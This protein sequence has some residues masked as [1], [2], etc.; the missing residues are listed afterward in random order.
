VQAGGSVTGLV[1]EVV[2][3]KLREKI[4]GETS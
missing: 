2:E 3:K 4:L 1:P